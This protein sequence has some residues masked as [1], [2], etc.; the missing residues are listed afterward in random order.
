M[1]KLSRLQKKNFIF[2][3]LQ[4]LILVIAIFFLKKEIKSI[5]YGSFVGILISLTIIFLTKKYISIKTFEI[6]IY[7]YPVLKITI[8]ILITYF[9][10]KIGIDSPKYFILSLIITNMLFVFNY[11]FY[12]TQGYIYYEHKQ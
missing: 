11:T 5:F 9:L 10:I 1:I 4:I 2:F 7:I 8:L 3:T 12:L 6:Y